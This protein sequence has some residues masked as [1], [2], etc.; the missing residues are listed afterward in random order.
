VRKKKSKKALPSKF[1]IGQRIAL[2]TRAGEV[3]GSVLECD[4]LTAV[5]AS[6]IDLTIR[7]RMPHVMIGTGK[8]RFL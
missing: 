7:Y 2:D 3:I 4:D 1:K 5:M 6:D 8:I